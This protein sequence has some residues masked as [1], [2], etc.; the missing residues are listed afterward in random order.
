[1][2]REF[3]LITGRGVLLLL[4]IALI[5]AGFVVLLSN[6]FVAEAWQDKKRDDQIQSI[7]QK[8]QP[9]PALTNLAE[10]SQRG[11]LSAAEQGDY[12]RLLHQQANKF[13]Q[14]R[15]ALKTM[16]VRE[17]DA[18][19]HAG[20][21]KRYENYALAYRGLSDAYDK[22]DANAVIAAREKALKLLQDAR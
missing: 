21:V 19:V 9:D 15:T 18:G 13:E 2:R 20:I 22:N 1:M 11:P 14:A 4:T 16:P 3:G 5:P 6:G 10:K 12:I 8:A 7:E 17:K